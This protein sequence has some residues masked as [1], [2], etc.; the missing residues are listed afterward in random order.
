MTLSAKETLFS[1]F[2]FFRLKFFFLNA[3]FGFMEQVSWSRFKAASWSRFH[4]A[5]SKRLHGAGSIGYF[6][7]MSKNKKFIFCP[8]W[9]K[10]KI[11]VRRS[12][13][14]KRMSNS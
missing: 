9:K 5:G 10:L 1:F 13:M 11:L 12:N 2:H 4:G 7:F 3:W 6:R 8:S 14:T